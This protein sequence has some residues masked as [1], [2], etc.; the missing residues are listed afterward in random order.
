LWGAAGIALDADSNIYFSCYDGCIWRIDQAGM[1]AR[2]TGSRGRDDLSGDGG[3][4]R[5]AFLGNPGALAIS[6]DGDLYVCSGWLVRKVCGVATP[7][8]TATLATED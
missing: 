5:D 4:A 8:G 7:P 2:V 3:P 6:R 1:L